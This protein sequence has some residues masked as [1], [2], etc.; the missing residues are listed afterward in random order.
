MLHWTQWLSYGSNKQEVTL[1]MFGCLY[2][3]IF[4]LNLTP[5]IIFQSKFT[6]SNCWLMENI[7][8][9]ISYLWALKTKEIWAALTHITHLGEGPNAADSYHNCWKK[10]I[11]LQMFSVSSNCSHLQAYFDLLAQPEC[12][13]GFNFSELRTTTTMIIP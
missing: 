12:M 5:L 13:L 7:K 11:T 9:K 3:L 8:L 10:D 4:F 6:K 1:A 2:Y